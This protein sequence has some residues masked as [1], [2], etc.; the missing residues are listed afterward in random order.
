MTDV[1]IRTATMRDLGP[2]LRLLAVMHDEEIEPQWGCA[3]EDLFQSI[4][5]DVDRRLLVAV[6]DGRVVGT[7]DV[8]VVRNLSRDSRPW[9]IIENL[10]VDPEFRRRGWGGALVKRCINFADESGCYK[11][12]LISNDRRSEAHS[13]YEDLGFTEPVR[14]FRMYLAEDLRH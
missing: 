3:E 14:G 10:S 12:Q 4:L 9:A 2:V 6:D 7:A 13:L 11:V 5:S 1:R 8:K